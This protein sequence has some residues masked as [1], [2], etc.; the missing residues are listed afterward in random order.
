MDK[1]N[2]NS[3]RPKNLIKKEFEDFK[4]KHLKRTDTIVIADQKVPCTNAKE[5]MMELLTLVETIRKHEKNLGTLVS[6]LEDILDSRDYMDDSGEGE[7][8]VTLL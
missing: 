8:G 4:N 1:E 2:Q 7:E 6:R 5:A 3:N